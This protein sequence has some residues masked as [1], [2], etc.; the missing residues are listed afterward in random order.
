MSFHWNMHAQ[1][2]GTSLHLAIRAIATACQGAKRQ[3]PLQFRYLFYS[4][5]PYANM[6]SGLNGLGCPASAPMRPNWRFGVRRI[7]GAS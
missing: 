2:K 5:S 6:L 3:R 7:S 1:G 4:T